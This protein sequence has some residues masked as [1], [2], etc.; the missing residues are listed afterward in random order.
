M[1]FFQSNVKFRQSLG[2]ENCIEYFEPVF[3]TIKGRG[4]TKLCISRRLHI[5]RVVID[6]FDCL[7]LY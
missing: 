3:Q 7:P 1:S 5:L 2:F 6:L 4:I